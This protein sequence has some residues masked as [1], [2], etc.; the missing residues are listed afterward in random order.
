[1]GGFKLFW[2]WFWLCRCCWWWCVKGYLIQN[3]M[4][5][6]AEIVPKRLDYHELIFVWYN[7]QTLFWLKKGMDIT[8]F[9]SLLNL[10]NFVVEYWEMFTNQLEQT[11]NWG[12]NCCGVDG[13]ELILTNQKLVAQ[14]LN[15]NEWNWH[16][17]V[18][19]MQYIEPLK[20][21]LVHVIYSFIAFLF[22]FVVWGGGWKYFFGG[23]II[24]KIFTYQTS[25]TGKWYYKYYN[26]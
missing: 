7:C 22:I 5:N 3:T 10:V 1:M 18:N 12:K 9:E 20:H 19:I 11:Q 24:L 17:K 26:Q 23:I 8:V 21:V 6:W 4:K 15:E 16:E 13:V 2:D 25:Y 14:T